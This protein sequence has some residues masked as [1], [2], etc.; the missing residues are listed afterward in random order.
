M[1]KTKTCP[2]CLSDIPEVATKCRSCAAKQPHM[3]LDPATIAMHCLIGIVIVFCGAFAVSAVLSDP[4]TITLGSTKTANVQSNLPTNASSYS[5]AK[6]II[7]SSLKT[8]STA[9]FPSRGMFDETSPYSVAQEGDVYTV[10]SFVDAQNEFGAMI[11]SEW[12]VK[13][14]FVGGDAYESTS[15][16]VLDVKIN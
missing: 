10:V 12:L 15:W 1:K 4:K 2:A 14:R 13:L 11:R 5:I 9:E 3:G 7:L 16:E 6:E 8:P